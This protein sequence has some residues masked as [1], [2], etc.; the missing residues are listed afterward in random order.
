M[1]QVC[2]PISACYCAPLGVLPVYLEQLVLF[3][4]S[5]VVYTS[6]C[7]YTYCLCGCIISTQRVQELLM[8]EH[9]IVLYQR[10]A[11]GP[12][13]HK[14]YA[15]ALC[16]VSCKAASRL[17]LWLPCSSSSK[18]SMCVALRTG[19][20]ILLKGCWCCCTYRLGC[21]TPVRSRGVCMLWFVLLVC[22]QLAQPLCGTSAQLAAV[23]PATRVH[24]ARIF[25]PGQHGVQSSCR[26]FQCCLSGVLRRHGCFT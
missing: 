26:F 23:C 6:W 14:V 8:Y 3:S 12:R 22:V 21:P 15:Q 9:H 11:T 20:C 18:N 2:T 16:G 24:M 5:T 4:I 13:A 10:I 17:F 19:P 25:L 1:L 7:M